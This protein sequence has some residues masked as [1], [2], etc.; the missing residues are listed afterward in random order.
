MNTNFTPEQIAENIN[1]FDFN[2]LFAA[3][4]PGKKI[5]FSTLPTIV[6]KEVEPYKCTLPESCIQLDGLRELRN[7]IR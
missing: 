3:C 2:A 4:G 1:N 6:K 5:D 7:A